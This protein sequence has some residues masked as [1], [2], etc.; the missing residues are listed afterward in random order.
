MTYKG[1]EMTLKVLTRAVLVFAL[2]CAGVF[3]QTVAS[4]V[5]GTVVDPAGKLVAGA[6]ATL[7][8]AGTAEVRTAV[9]DNTGTFRFLNIPAGTYTVTIREPGFKAGIETDVVVHA[10]EN[11]SA[12]K[13]T[14]QAGSVTEFSSAP[15]EPR[16]QVVDP[17]ESYTI[18]A[19]DLEVLTQK[20]RDLFGYMHLIPGVVD[21]ANSR[22]VTNPESIA[23]VTI[24]GNAPLSSQM[25]FNVDGITDLDTGVDNRIHFEPN[26][27]SIREIRVLEANYQA[28]YGRNSGG[29]VTVI[30]RNGTQDFHGTA[31]WTHRNT[32]FNANSW[33]NNHTLTSAGTAEPRVGYRFNVETYGIGGPLFIPHI[34]NQ[35]KK[36]LFFFF[37]QERTQQYIPAPTQ[38]TYMPTTAERGGDFSQTFSNSNGNPVSIP[39]LDPLNNNTQFAGNVIPLSRITPAGQEL[40][41]LFPAPN[42]APTQPS[43]LYIDNYFEQG[44]DPNTRRNDVLRIDASLTPKTTANIRW[45]NDHQD[46]KYLFNGVQFNQ[47]A[48]SYVYSSN[49]S[50]IDNPNP[51]HGYQGTITTAVTPTLINDFTVGESWN[52]VGYYTT[53]NYATESRSLEPNL[54]ILFTLPTTNLN[55]EVVSLTNGYQSLLPTFTFGGN[56]LPSSAHYLRNGPSAGAAEDF[57]QAWTVQDNI[58][59]VIGRHAFKAGFYGERTTRLQ[60]RSQNY[61][62]EYSFAANSSDPFLNTNDGY[63]NA[64]LGDVASYTQYTAETTSDILFYNA[65]FYLQDNWKVSSRLSVDLGMRFYHQTAPIDH[66]N[67]FVNFIPADFSKSAESRLYYPA[68]SGVTTCSSA[69]NGLVARDKLT[70]AIVPSPYIGD[71]VVGSGNPVSGMVNLGE[72]KVPAA[73]Y[74]QSSLAFGPRIGFAYDLFGNG[75][76]AIR[77]GFGIYHDRL[78]TS[79]V[80]GLAGQEPLV[81]QQTVHDVTF[82]QIA[83]IDAGTTPALTNLTIAPANVNAWPSSVPFERVDNGSLD[84]QHLFGNGMFVNLGYTMN[85]SYN[86]YLTYDSNYIPIGTS[87]P[88]TPSNLSPTTSG[89]TSAD[90]GSIYERTLYP[91][92]GSI[93]TAAFL[94]SSKYNAATASF[95]KRIAQG[96]SARAVYTWSHANGVTTYSPEVSNNAGYNYGRLASDRRHNL[97]ITYVYSIP[98]FATKMGWNKV[99]YVTNHWTLS[100]ITSI[101][102]GAPY[103]PTC[104]VTAGDPTPASYTG[105]PDLT[106]RCNVVGNPGSGT[107]SGANGTVYFNAAAFALPALATGPNNSL[108]GPAVLGNLGGGAGVLTLPHTTNFDVTLTKV[109]PIF[110][111]ERRVLKLQVQAYNVFNHTEISGVYSGIQFNPTNNAVSNPSGV[112]YASSAFPNRVLAFTA[113]LVF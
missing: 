87:W 18:D 81:Y 73:P 33:A 98:S 15:A 95:S 91:G 8:S 110:G 53:D 58:S 45:M 1:K 54:P 89:S 97:Q 2:C 7:T 55:K 21:S 51:G 20:G 48:G 72:N 26:L 12:G 69:A 84:I 22:D 41:E 24:D 44:S 96:L 61:N 109:I 106:A 93:N 70:G 88:F 52:Q 16:V 79:T 75:K 76:T 13:I 111:S 57:N 17:A 86:Q 56:G 82:A 27:D 65:E 35:D 4:T 68:C 23:G 11:V 19:G 14:L 67:T 78:P 80:A 60:P 64:L 102:S 59:K 42:Y 28:E 104:S 74:T 5:I 105:T 39:I 40:L 25:N 37:S 50:A 47:T 49:I 66:D 6:P 46:T 99:G 85:Y 71:I 31:D 9:T 107:T 63:V 100:G 30:T 32:E 62:G 3:A 92:Y 94:G 112:G 43:Q 108:T 101:E 34:A 36:K 103:N 90:I 113:R 83:A 77:G 29:I 38:T 10:Q